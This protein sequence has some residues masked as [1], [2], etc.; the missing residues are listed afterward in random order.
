MSGELMT[1]RDRMRFTKNT[2]SSRLALL[3]IV[4]NVL[5][6]VSIYKVN[7]TEYYTWLM[8]ISILYNLVFMLAAFLSSE[9]V[10]NYKVPFSF[11]LLALAAGQVV[12]IFIY[13]PKMYNIPLDPKAQL[14]EVMQVVK[15]QINVLD[16]TTVEE[17]SEYENRVMDTFQYIR[18]I[19]YLSLSA[20]CLAASAVINILKSRALSVHIASLNPEKI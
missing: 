6:F 13:P 16:G 17:V 19:A 20:L 14:G 5:F 2:L 12:R 1:R 8:G 18:T 10:K 11:L 4:F 3:A 15:T 7:N 9:G